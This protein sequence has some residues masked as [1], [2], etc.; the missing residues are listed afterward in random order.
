MPDIPLQA[1]VQCSDGPCGKATN[2]IINPVTHVVSH[3][4]VQDKHLPKYDTRLV[5][6]DTVAET[7]PKQITLSC[8]KADVAAMQP[9]WVD[10]FVQASGSGQAYSAGEAYSSQYVYNDTAY[11]SV[12]AANLPK[13][14][15]PIHAGMQVEASDGKV[16]KLDELVLDPQ[17]GAITHIMLREGHLWGKKDVAISLADID[18]FHGETIY[19][20]QDKKAIKALPAVKVKR[21]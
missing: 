8:S 20:N 19:L 1:K 5:P 7:T 3:L 18:Y 6:I 17:S 12:E 15:L 11:D 13:G 9:F 10:H 4:V 21:S 2:V 14:E 16:G